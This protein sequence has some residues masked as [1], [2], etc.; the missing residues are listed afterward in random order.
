MDKFNQ[1]ISSLAPKKK[2]PTSSPFYPTPTGNSPRVTGVFAPPKPTVMPVTSNAGATNPVVR[3]TN[4]P[5]TLP[6]AGQQ[7]VNNI[8]AP[9]KR[10]TNGLLINPA[11]AKFDRNTGKPIGGTT[12]TA[13]SNPTSTPTAPQSPYLK[14][15]NSLFDPSQLKSASEA[16]INANKRLANIQNRN[17]TQQLEGR[18]NYEKALD[19]SGGL[20]SG[21]IQ[22]A[23]GIQRRASAESAYGA[24]EESAAARTAGVYKDVYDQMLGAGKTV[25]EAETAAAK[26]EQDQENKQRE[27]GQKDTQIAQDAEKLKQDAEKLRFDQE[28]AQ[29]KFEE[30]KRQFGL[31]YALKKQELNQ[32]AS[33]ASAT[34]TG[35]DAEALG[36]MNLINTLIDNP[37]VD[38]I[39]G[40]IQGGL[41]LGNLDP[42]SNV[43]L[44]RNQFN[45]VKG[46]LA[47]EN[48]AKLKGQGAVSDFEGRTLESAASALG[49]NLGDAEGIRQLRQVRGAIATSH[50]LSA[51]VLI[52]DPETKQSQTLLSDSA[53][54]AKAI[55][56]GLIVEYK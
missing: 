11:D 41:K 17:E 18:V 3:K 45:Q 27:F 33:E 53:G 51:D 15:L 32:K 29:K 13:P 56:D 35:K 34:A 4:T 47:L 31:E 23:G 50:G 40:A 39:F 19:E 49:R 7:Y 43:Q 12:P 26:A 30:D 6:P 44:A 20:R 22:T 8:S 38:A 36:S 5:S 37:N 54:I 24:L 1:F 42:R 46:A 14:Y 9:E 48:R 55:Q 10:D 21:A 2:A 52:Y 28:F 25:F 16:S